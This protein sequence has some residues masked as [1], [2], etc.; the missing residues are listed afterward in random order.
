MLNDKKNSGSGLVFTSQQP[1]SKT[2]TS[3]PPVPPI[4]ITINV[5]SGE[6]NLPLRPEV[7]DFAMNMETKLLKNE[8][9][10]G[11]G[12]MTI[13]ELIAHIED[14]LG[15]LKAAIH[16]NLSAEEVRFEAADTANFFMM[17]AENYTDEHGN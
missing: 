14:E 7:L 5:N 16:L 8:H 3:A 17:L 1:A 4:N 15:E 9:K 6:E 11:W 10:G 12:G 2:E 13:E